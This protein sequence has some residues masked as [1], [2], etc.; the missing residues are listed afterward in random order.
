MRRNGMGMQRMRRNGMAHIMRQ[1]E[2]LHVLRREDGRARP[3]KMRVF[4]G[5]EVPGDKGKRPVQ[6]GRMRKMEEG[7]K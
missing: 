2:I 3:G 6:A 4:L 5:G 1:N 7:Q